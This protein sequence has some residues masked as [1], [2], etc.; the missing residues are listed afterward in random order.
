MAAREQAV[1]VRAAAVRRGTLAAIAL[2]LLGVCLAKELVRAVFGR[3]QLLVVTHLG[4]F[5]VASLSAFVVLVL[6]IA[7]SPH[8]RRRLGPEG[9]APA[10]SRAAW[11][12]MLLSAGVG[13]GLLV[14]GVAEPGLH[15]RTPGSPAFADPRAAGGLSA[16][17]WG[18]HAWAVYALVG[19]AFA[20]VWR[21]PGEKGEKDEEDE[22]DE[23]D[24]GLW[25]MAELLRPLFGA[26]VEGRAGQLVDVLAASSTT[27]GVATSLGLAAT[28]LR[29]GLAGLF[30]ESPEHGV[31]VALLV[32]LVAGLTGLT[33]WALVREE[34]G[35]RRLSA[36]GL[37]LSGLLA[38]TVLVLGP[39]AELGRSLLENLGAYLE[40]FGARALET[41]R[42]ATPAERA[43]LGEWTVFYWA[44]WVSW[45]PF[46]GLFIAR[47][48]R[49][50]SVRELLLGVLLC[51][52]AACLVWMS[53][54]GGAAVLT[55]VEVPASDPGAALFELLARLCP[56]PARVG[57]TLASLACCACL[58]AVSVASAVLALASL[59]AGGGATKLGAKL[60]WL[61]ALSGSAL[62][63]LLA[64]G[65]DA[66]RA[67]VLVV[68]LPLCAVL[69]LV[70][71]ALL[72]VLRTPD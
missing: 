10:H 7:L 57:L 38:L 49:G 31:L 6:G 46:V 71:V 37:G 58:A 24:K 51:P 23:E 45:A 44:W 30:V 1:E 36:V 22:E 52:S 13:S 53:V 65:L 34:V 56:S 4:W 72:R 41:G 62:V 61:F 33:A 54:F 11:L 2:A 19:L 16:F 14:Y 29:S 18:L 20:W 32:A 63:L 55:G 21:R 50:R 15:L 26:R 67:V 64:G 5:Y 25:S 42:S 17:H 39:S 40:I 47:I 48:S 27:F 43:W 9:A 8:G 3:L 69:V 60:A 70:A 28:Q 59:G 35:I 66:L 68:S 12:G